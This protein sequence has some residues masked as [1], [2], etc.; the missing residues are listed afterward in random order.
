MLQ[1]EDSPSFA[2]DR[3]AAWDT[4]RPAEAPDDEKAAT[5]LFPGVPEAADAA[6]YVLL[7]AEVRREEVVAAAAR[8]LVLRGSDCILDTFD[9]SVCIRD[10]R[11]LRIRNIG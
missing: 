10:H 6:D 7:A 5:G 2:D 4:D 1:E 11:I 8:Y 9:C 3:P